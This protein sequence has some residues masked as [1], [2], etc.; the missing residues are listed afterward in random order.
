LVHTC[1]ISVHIRQE[2]ELEDSRSVH[3]C[4]ISV[5]I[6]ISI[7]KRGVN[8]SNISLISISIRKRGVNRS[9]ISLISLRKRK[10]TF[11]FSYAYANYAYVP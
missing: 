3:T 2:L 4:D 9:N 10:E 6:S 8:R 5:N 7:R 11:P 1:D